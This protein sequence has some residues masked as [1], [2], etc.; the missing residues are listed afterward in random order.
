MKTFLKSRL[1]VGGVIGILAWWLTPVSAQALIPVNQLALT[2]QDQQ[3]LRTAL[4]HDSE[5]VTAITWQGNPLPIT[6]ALRQEQRLIFP[7]PVQVD[8]NGQLTTAQL[9]VINDHQTVYLTA[10]QNFEKTTRIYVTLKGAVKL[11]S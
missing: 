2:A 8:I 3:A 4:P 6:L 7:E 5:S 9:Q 1:R 10:L 11:F